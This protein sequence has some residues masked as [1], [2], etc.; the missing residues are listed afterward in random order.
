MMEAA[1]GA[2]LASP[3]ARLAR[4]GA[5]GSGNRAPTAP[6]AAGATAQR[7]RSRGPVARGKGIVEAVSETLRT[8]EPCQAD[9]GVLVVVVVERPAAP[10]ARHWKHRR[11]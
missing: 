11:M 8:P 6:T 3:F 5:G 1:G 4:G 7:P 2:L 9:K 10:G